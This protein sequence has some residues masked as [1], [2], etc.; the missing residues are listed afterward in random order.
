[1]FLISDHRNIKFFVCN[2]SLDVAIRFKLFSCLSDG[3]SCSCRWQ[4]GFK[5]KMILNT[6]LE[7]TLKQVIIA[8]FKNLQEEIVKNVRISV[9]WTMIR[10]W[11]HPNPVNRFLSSCRVASCSVYENG[12][13]RNSQILITASPHRIS[14]SNIKLHYCCLHFIHFQSL[15]S[16]RFISL[17][18]KCR[19]YSGYQTP[20]LPHTYY[21]KTKTR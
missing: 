18:G 6:E 13:E 15:M 5:D 9:F 3:P 17:F 16:A 14:G 21:H 2:S 1:M 8:W 20:T 12:L 7:L 19:S 11:N 10:T 4:K